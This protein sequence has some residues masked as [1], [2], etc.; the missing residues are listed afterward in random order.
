MV[1]KGASAPLIQGEIMTVG[2][3]VFDA[4]GRLVIDMTRSYSQ[5]QGNVTTNAVN[6]SITIPPL[7]AGKRR[8]YFVVGMGSSNTWRGKLP[9][10]TVSGNVLSWQYLFSPWFGAFAQN[11]TIYY[12]YY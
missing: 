11:A 1:K 5:H 12:G 7:P 9:G 6:G 2:I 8:F 4:G 10:V 3:Q